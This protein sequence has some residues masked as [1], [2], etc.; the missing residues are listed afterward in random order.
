MQTDLAYQIQVIQF[1]NS[2]ENRTDGGDGNPT[3]NQTIHEV[4]DDEEEDEEESK[5]DQY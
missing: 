4:E 3:L 2:K 5:Y 1:G